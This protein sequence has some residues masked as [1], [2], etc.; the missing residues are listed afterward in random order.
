MVAIFWGSR[1]VERSGCQLGDRLHPRS[2]YAGPQ[3]FN[4]DRGNWG[5]CRT[6]PSMGHYRIY[7]LDPS[8]HVTAGFSV[9]CGSDAAALRA[10]RALLELQQSAGVEV[11]QSTNRLAHLSLEAQP[12]WDQRREEWMAV[13]PPL[14]TKTTS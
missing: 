11:W 10:A 2:T 6:F 8:D 5:C 7:Q 9:E 1:N 12:L 13:A 4:Y 3:I 14:N